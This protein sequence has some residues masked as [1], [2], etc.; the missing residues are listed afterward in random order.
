MFGSHRIKEWTFL[1]ALVTLTVLLAGCAPQESG[2]AG[3]TYQPG[4]AERGRTLFATACVQCHG[5]DGTGIQG[6]GSDL[7][8]STKRLQLPDPNLLDFL[9]LGH[10]KPEQPVTDEQWRD[11]IAYIRTIQPR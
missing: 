6:M 4:D 2:S 8:A 3:S 5:T 9:K 10:P 7:T 11:L 1:A